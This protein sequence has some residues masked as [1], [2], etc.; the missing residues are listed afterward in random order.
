MRDVTFVSKLKCCAT[1]KFLKHEIH[2]PEQFW[3][4]TFQGLLICQLLHKNLFFIF[5]GIICRV[6]IT[7]DIHTYVCMYQRTSIQMYIYS[8]FIINFLINET[9]HNGTVIAFHSAN[10]GIFSLIGRKTALVIQLRTILIFFIIHDTQYQYLRIPHSI[11]RILF[12]I[13]FQHFNVKVNVYLTFMLYTLM[14]T[15]KTFNRYPTGCS[16]NLA[17]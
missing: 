16:Q 14:Y 8:L 9:A 17:A 6:N 11:F 13:F 15:R 4:L 5:L 12:F 1:H 10:L 2:K 3:V 7:K